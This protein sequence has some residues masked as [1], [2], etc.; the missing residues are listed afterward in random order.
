MKKFSKLDVLETIGFIGKKFNR[1]TQQFETSWSL[2]FRSYLNLFLL[3]TTM[4]KYAVSLAFDQTDP[5]Q[6]YIG[7]FWTYLN[8]DSQ[9]YLSIVGVIIISWAVILFIV[10]NRS[11]R[12]ENR[13][14]MLWLRI[15][16]ELAADDFQVVGLPEKEN[17]EFLMAEDRFFLLY[18]K[19]FAAVL[20]V[21]L[22]VLNVQLY[23]IKVNNMHVIRICEL[24][25]NPKSFNLVLL[26][27]TTWT[28]SRT[29]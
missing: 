20:I 28:T 14:F 23:F 6:L 10:F 13:S 18:M 15:S 12:A 21:S 4:S 2:R 25:Q 24:K 27:S 8:H 16:G 29:S 3:A 1:S 17:K 11:N 22:L 9:F 26:F 7:S 19:A 5:I